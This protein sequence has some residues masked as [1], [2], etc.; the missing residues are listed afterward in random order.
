MNW[1]VF[2]EAPVIIG[3][4]IVALLV[5]PCG[6][7]TGFALSSAVSKDVPVVVQTEIVTQEVIG[8]CPESVPCPPEKEC[9]EVYF[10]NGLIHQMRLYLC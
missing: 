8:D 3:L 1:D 9:P 4:I 2:K 6:V 7:M 10:K 5:C